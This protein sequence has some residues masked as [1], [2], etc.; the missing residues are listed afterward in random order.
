MTFWVLYLFFNWFITGLFNTDNTII[1]QISQKMK[2]IDI[3]YKKSEQ[4]LK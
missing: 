4:L 2:I 3:V 1:Y